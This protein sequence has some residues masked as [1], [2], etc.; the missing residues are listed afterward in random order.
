MFA[1]KEYC[2]NMIMNSFGIMNAIFKVQ[3]T[4]VAITG[5]GFILD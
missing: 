4:Y 5:I 2:L 3:A 1:I